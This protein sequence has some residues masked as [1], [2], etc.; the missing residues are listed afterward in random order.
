M[1]KAT[2]VKKIKSLT[3]SEEASF[4]KDFKDI[5]LEKIA[6]YEDPKSFFE[7]L[8]Y[9]GCISGMISEFIYNADCKKFYI[10]HIDDLEWMRKDMEDGLGEAIKNRH[11]FP[12]YVFMCHLC[13]E[14]Y[15]YNLYNNIYGN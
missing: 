8:Q 2:V 10:E 9:G 13:F 7:D 15:C 14:E 6:D 11:D 1:K 5:V 3:W 4:E 12:H